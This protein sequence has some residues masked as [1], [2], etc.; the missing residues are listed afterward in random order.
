MP[1]ER[2]EDVAARRAAKA[3][4]ARELAER[5]RELDD[6]IQARLLLVLCAH[7]IRGLDELAALLRVCPRAAAD[8]AA[9]PDFPRPVSPTGDRVRL[10]KTA[11]VI[12]WLDSQVVVETNYQGAVS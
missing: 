9:R 8:I 12:A 1:F 5:Q 7:F 6:A 11:A 10:W 2:P 4:R 3:E